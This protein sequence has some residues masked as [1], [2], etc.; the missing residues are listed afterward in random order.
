MIKNTSQNRSQNHQK[1]I[2]NWSRIGPLWK[3]KSIKNCSILGDP[4]F[5][6]KVWEPQRLLWRSKSYQEGVWSAQGQIRAGSGG[7]FGPNLVPTWAHLGS[8]NRAKKCWKTMRKGVNFWMAFGIQL[9]AVL[10]GFR[11]RKWSHV[12]SKIGSKM[13]VNL[14][15]SIFNKTFKNH[16]KNQYFG[17]G[18]GSSW[19]QNWAQDRSQNGVPD[20][21]HLNIDFWSILGPKLG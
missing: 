8:Q 13:D 1:S 7:D 15:W 19:P 4:A 11:G 18:R 12:G 6:W 2:K 17:V 9:G 16:C 14:K 20:K 10:G 5:F 3:Q 21:M